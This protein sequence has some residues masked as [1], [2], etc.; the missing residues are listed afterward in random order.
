M[1]WNIGQLCQYVKVEGSIESSG[2]IFFKDSSKK[3]SFSFSLS[4][5]TVAWTGAV[6]PDIVGWGAPSGV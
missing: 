4:L 1:S 2:S 3:I 5:G 6:V